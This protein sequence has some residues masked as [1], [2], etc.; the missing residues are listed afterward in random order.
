M[1]GLRSKAATFKEF[2]SD[3]TSH[4]DCEEYFWLFNSNKCQNLNCDLV[5][6]TLFFFHLKIMTAYLVSLVVTKLVSGEKV[7]Q[8]YEI[9]SFV[10]F[11]V[12]IRNIRYY[13]T[14]EKLS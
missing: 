10:L 5:R 8:S 13:A 7:Y 9:C 2:T 3:G 14:I 1:M 6:K 11:W 12:K 4:K